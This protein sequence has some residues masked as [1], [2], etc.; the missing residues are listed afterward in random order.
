MTVDKY[1]ENRRWWE[2]AIVAS[3]VLLSFFANLGVVWMEFARR[4]GGF[5]A[6]EPWVLEATS[7]LGLAFII[8]LVIWFDRRFPITATSWKTSL[9]AHALFSVVASLVHVTIMYWSRIALFLTFDPGS[10]YH[11]DS[12]LREF[13]Y[14]YLKDFRTYMLILIL[15]YLYRFIILRLQGEAGFVGEGQDEA[16][17]EVIS[18][19][20]LVKKLGREFLVRID[21]IDW[22]ESSGNY[23]N[24][25]VRG[26]VYPLRDTMT[27]IS[28]R[29]NPHGFQRVH[30]SAIV[31]LDRVA[32]IV[33]FDTG[34]GEA[35]LQSDITV[36][37]S[38]R[39]KKELRE[40]LG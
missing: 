24:L 4:P 5:D 6:W 31:N 14:E 18:D 40:R 8:P 34:D 25:H 16:S 22:V 27:S 19:R 17:P 33:A 35:R 2:F 10:S 39:F 23:V 29:L 30:R 12:W 36:P 32:E 7:H 13:R 9:P 37:I 28:E 11:W 26:R 1:L 3:F 20:F 15:L 38:R 21:E